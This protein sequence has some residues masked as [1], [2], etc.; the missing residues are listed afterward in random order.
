MGSKIYAIT[1]GKSAYRH[2]EAFRRFDRNKILD[3]I[4][5]QLTFK[6]QEK[7][8]NKKF[9]RE[10]PLADWEL[11]IDSYRIFYDIDESKQTV[12]ILAIG[13]KDHEKIIIDGE[14][15]IL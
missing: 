11:R 12:R 10:N 7:T 5:E 1:F 4:K 3:G 2:L 6:P 14:E 9:L 8:R 15:I 13:I